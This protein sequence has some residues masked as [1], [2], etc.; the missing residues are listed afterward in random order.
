MQENKALNA[1]NDDIRES[2]VKTEALNKELT[3]YTSR[4]EK[5]NEKLDSDLKKLQDDH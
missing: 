2:L 4:L 1:T 3:D 5:I